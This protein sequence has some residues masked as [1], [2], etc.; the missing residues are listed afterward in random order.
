[1][2]NKPVHVLPVDDLRPH[3]ETGTYC[4]CKPRIEREGGG[5]VVVHNAYD[6]R[7]FYENDESK[8]ENFMTTNAPGGEIDM[9]DEKQ[10]AEYT[11]GNHIMLRCPHCNEQY[12]AELGNNPLVKDGITITPVS[13]EPEVATDVEQ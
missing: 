11:V 6:G 4:H 8:G 1:M 10:K 7:E 3:I 9:G 12:E 2:S 5:T 13:I